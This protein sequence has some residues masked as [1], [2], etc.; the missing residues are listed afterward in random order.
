[1]AKYAKQRHEIVLDFLVAIGVDA[2]TAEIDSE[3]IEH[4]VSAK[5]LAAMKSFLTK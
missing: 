3:G 4:H 5:T 2:Q 1:M